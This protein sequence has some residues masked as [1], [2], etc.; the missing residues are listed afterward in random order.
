MH[1][2]IDATA[3]ANACARCP[4]PD[5]GSD[6]YISTH[7][8]RPVFLSDTSDD[9]ANAA[10]FTSTWEIGCGKGHVLLLPSGADDHEAFGQARDDDELGDDLIRLRR[11]IAQGLA[12]A[13]TWAVFDRWAADDF[14]PPSMAVVGSVG[15]SRDVLRVAGD[16]DRIGRDRDPQSEDGDRG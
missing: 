7:S 6:L 13:A 15:A 3:H 2:P 8:S 16:L 1:E 9:L 5:C 11:L 10:P 12:A 14:T 4:L